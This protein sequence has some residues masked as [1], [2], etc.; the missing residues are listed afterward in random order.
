MGEARPR[1]GTGPERAVSAVPGK[2]RPRQK[3]SRGRRAKAADG[4]WKPGRWREQAQAAKD[5]GP[6]GKSRGA[7]KTE[8]ARPGDGGYGT[9]ETKDADAGR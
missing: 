9:E 6:A 3:E 7:G 8:A 2:T 5:T 1:R 4:G